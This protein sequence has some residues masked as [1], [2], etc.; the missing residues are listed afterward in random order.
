METRDYLRILKDDMHSTVMATND[1]E[2]RPVTRVIDIMLADDSTLYF[3]T[4]RGKEFYD[5]LTGQRFVSVTGVCGGEGMDKREA[6]LH[7]KA[8]TIRGTVESIGSEKLDEIFEKNPYMADIYPNEIS[9]KAL[10]VFRIGEGVGEYFDLTTKPIT[11]TNFHVGSGKADVR[12]GG[13]FITDACI[14]CG[15][16]LTVCPQDCI[17]SGEIPFVIAREHCIHCGNCMENCPVEAIIKNF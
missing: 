6:T 1:S 3:L 8:I 9:R 11:R 15:T 16:C 5:Q 4:A 7:M 13:Y 10:E 12:V 2:G 17:S 14:G